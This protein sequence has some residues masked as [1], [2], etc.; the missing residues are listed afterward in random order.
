MELNEALSKLDEL[1]DTGSSGQIESFIKER[2][3]EYRPADGGYSAAYVTFLNEAGSFY[4]RTSRYQKCEEAFLAAKELLEK[5]G[6]TG[7]DAYATILNNLA[8]AYRMMGAYDKALAFFEQAMRLYA[9]AGGEKSYLY[10]SALNNMGLLYLAQKQYPKAAEHLKR[11]IA[12][13][14]GAQDSAVEIAISQGN[15]AI[16]CAGMGRY[17]KAF[18]LAERSMETFRQAEGENSLLYATGLNTLATLHMARQDYAE[19]KKCWTAALAVLTGRFG[20]N[21]AD[22]AAALESL[23]AVCARLNEKEDALRYGQRAADI[24][25]TLL[26]AGHQKTLQSRERLRALQ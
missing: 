26:G 16:A 15:L 1:F 2:L 22:V 3:A 7:S 19:A 10:A 20:E 11:A 21:Q 12:V 8:G 24:Y 9:A 5:N 17:D 23:S 13:M 6:D 4:R 14:R 25:E 18:L